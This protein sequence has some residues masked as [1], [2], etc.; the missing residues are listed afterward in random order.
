MLKGVALA[1]YSSFSQ[2][3]LIGDMFS[4]WEQMGFFSYILPFLLI[5][6]LV[7][8]ILTQM[9]MFR[10]NR[11]VNAIIALV[12]GLMALQLDMVSEFFREIF[13][14]LG[15]GLAIL[16]VILILAGLFIDPERMP[17][18]ITLLVIGVIISIVVLINT[19]GAVGWSSAYIWQEYASSIVM[20]IILL[21]VIG[22]IVGSGSN[23]PSTS[24][25][26]W[27]NRN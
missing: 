7:Y 2:G 23:R 26:P 15:V 25:N 27:I 12:V 16:L 20:I 13:P 14:R 5:F 11:S 6:A 4:Q 1:S 9:K 22:V 17:L 3:G 18:M 21:V 8:G 19:A 10:D 24:Y